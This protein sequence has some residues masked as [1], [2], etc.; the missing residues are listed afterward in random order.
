[1]GSVRSFLFVSFRSF[2]LF[3]YGILAM[4]DG[5]VNDFGSC[6]RFRLITQSYVGR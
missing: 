2:R 6:N 4:P 3:T 5:A 1:M